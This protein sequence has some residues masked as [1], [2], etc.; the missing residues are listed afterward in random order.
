M[1][2]T[3]S[4]SSSSVVGHGAMGHCSP[5]PVTTPAFKR[6]RLS[7]CRSKWVGAVKMRMRE[8]G[9]KSGKVLAAPHDDRQFGQQQF[10][11]AT[12][13]GATKARPKP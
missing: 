13:A 10:R 7:R 9:I 11:I 3:L 1:P 4:S 5:C 12:L 6:N 2:A 8:R